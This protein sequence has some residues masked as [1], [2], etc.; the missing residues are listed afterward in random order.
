[1]EVEGDKCKSNSPVAWALLFISPPLPCWK[2]KPPFLF[3]STPNPIPIP[4]LFNHLST[5]W[6]QH[7]HKAGAWTSR[8]FFTYFF[9]F[10][11]PHSSFRARFNSNFTL[12]HKQTPLIELASPFTRAD[13]EFAYLI[14]ILFILNLVLK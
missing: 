13:L 7:F 12:F 9:R 14:F 10:L 4:I 8:H 1:M 3:L 11:L 6:M 2:L 5:P